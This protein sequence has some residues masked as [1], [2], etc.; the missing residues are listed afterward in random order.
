MCRIL[1]H[2]K[3]H[4]NDIIILHFTLI[5]YNKHLDAVKQIKRDFITEIYIY[6]HYQ[7]EKHV[8]IM[9]KTCSLTP[10]IACGV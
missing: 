1:T 5:S 3:F 9:M 8:K 4:I 2:T 6:V 10:A 7:T